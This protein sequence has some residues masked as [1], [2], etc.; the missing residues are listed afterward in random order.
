MLTFLSFII[1]IFS[2][3][4]NDEESA[5]LTFK[6]KR[7]LMNGDWIVEKAYGNGKDLTDT[8]KLNMQNLLF[9]FTDQK[10]YYDNYLYQVFIN[11]QTLKGRYII[12]K[13]YPTNATIVVNSFK[14]YMNYGTRIIYLPILEKNQLDSMA[15]GDTIVY[16]YYNSI[17]TNKYINDNKIKLSCYTNFYQEIILRKL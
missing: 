13:V 4:K 8:L 2:C 11:D 14:A 7:M 3:K 12:K 10:D 16:D 15:N 17:Y 5:F 1:L 6:N 9:R